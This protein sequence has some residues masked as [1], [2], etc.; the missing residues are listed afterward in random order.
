MRLGVL[1]AALA[2]IAPL[3]AAM[4]LSAAPDIDRSAV[5]RFIASTA[6][7]TRPVEEIL[8]GGEQ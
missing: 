8:E 3:L 4:T 7:E 2:V 6:F 1:I 5:L